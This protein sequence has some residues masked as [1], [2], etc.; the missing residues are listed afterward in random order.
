MEAFLAYIALPILVGFVYFFI[1][2][3]I[4]RSEDITYIQG[5]ILPVFFLVVF[6][7]PMTSQDPTGWASFGRGVMVIFS[8]VI[9]IT[10]LLSW[11]IVTLVSKSR[12][13]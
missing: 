13:I 6:L 12:K 7:L 3:L 8:A 11:L 10:Y 1:V 2:T 4:K 9:L 5:M